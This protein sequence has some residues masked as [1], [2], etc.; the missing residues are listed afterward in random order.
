VWWRYF[1]VKMEYGSSPVVSS[2]PT[3]MRMMGEIIEKGWLTRRC[4][5]TSGA[6]TKRFE[7]ELTLA[8]LAAE[9]QSRWAPEKAVSIDVVYRG[10]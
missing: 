1:A 6:A 10:R 2:G 5:P 9:R 7:P 4:R 8:P 3:G